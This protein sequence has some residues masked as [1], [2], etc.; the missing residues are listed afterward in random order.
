M[1]CHDVDQ[2]LDA[3]I[4]GT[5]AAGERATVDAHL[6]QCASC[7]D[8]LEQM[9]RV[10]AD[11][12][13]LPREIQPSRDLW[14]DIAQRLAPRAKPATPGRS[15]SRSPSGLAAAAVLLIAVG[16]AI[17]ATVSR[18]RQPATDTAFTTARARYTAA[19]ATLAEQLAADPGLLAVT[20]RSV[21]AQDLD[22]LDR[23]IREAEAALAADPRSAALEQMLLKREQQRIDLLERAL[24]AGRQEI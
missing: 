17:G 1:T 18:W 2:Q 24:R 14:A 21:I 4:D 16:G 11:S 19:A 7:R 5:L 8:A 20:T 3:Y 12:H 22:I 15:W 23:A 6:A 10:L 13:A 9:R